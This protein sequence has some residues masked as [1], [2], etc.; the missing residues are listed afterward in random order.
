M[1]GNYS[2]QQSI[3]FGYRDSMISG[4]MNNYNMFE[5]LGSGFRLFDYTLD[6]KSQNHKGLFFDNLSFSNFGYGGDPN[7]V[8]RLHVDKNKL[9]DFRAMFRRDEYFFDYDLLAN[10]LNITQLPDGLHDGVHAG[11]DHEFAA[12]ALSR[13]QHAGLRSDSVA[14]NRESGSAWA[15]PTFSKAARAIPPSKVATDAELSQITATTTDAYRAGVDYK[16]IARTVFSFDELLNYTKID[17]NATDTNFQ[18]QLS[19]GTPVD[20]GIV[21]QGTT[22]CAT[23]VTNG[24]TTPADGHRKLQRLL[25]YSKVAKSEGFV[26]CGTLQLR[27]RL[28]QEFA[29]ERRGRLLG[30]QQHRPRFQ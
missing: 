8:S 26:S 5:N 24:A 21:F 3:E 25:S 4:N 9:Y 1:P 6:L 19:N 7:S 12:R 2:I 11:G 17:Q 28:F 29:D 18:Y 15:T 10:P 23:P 22:P 30:R 27:V 14:A 13:P 16:G 20:L